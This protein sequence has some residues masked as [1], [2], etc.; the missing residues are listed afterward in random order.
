MFQVLV[1]VEEQGFTVPMLVEEAE[2]SGTNLSRGGRGS[3]YQSWQERKRFQVPVLV[4]EAEVPEVP[5]LV[6]E[7]KIPGTSSSRAGRNSRY[8]FL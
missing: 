6:G 7:A 4:E 1:L 5:M 3:R 8:Q 2:V